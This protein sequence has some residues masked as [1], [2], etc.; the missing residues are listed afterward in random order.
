MTKR[1]LSPRFNDRDSDILEHIVRYRMSTPEILHKL[2]FSDSELN[3]VTK[4]TSRLVKNGFL[5]RYDLHSGKSY[6]SVGPNSARMYGFAAKKC[7]EI[8]EQAIISEY[9]MLQYCC[10]SPIPRERLLVSELLDE[11]GNIAG[12]KLR[13]ATFYIDIQDGVSRLACMRVDHG[14]PPPHVVRKCRTDLES[15]VANAA[16]AD[17]VRR[18][19]FVMAVI[20]CNEQKVRFIQDSIARQTWPIQFR[21]EAVPD[22]TPLILESKI[23]LDSEELEEA[24]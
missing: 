23:H 7:R 10:L 9:G 6:F 24:E 11:I 19:R 16:I 4:V 22:L 12:K 18:Q 21:V 8:G 15:L 3:A 20:T 1:R 5:N 2:F 14:G 13:P 17:Y